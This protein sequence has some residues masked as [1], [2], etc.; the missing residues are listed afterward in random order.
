LENPK[1]D[2]TSFYDANDSNAVVTDTIKLE[3]TNDSNLLR[4][5]D[6]FCICS[7]D[8]GNEGGELSAYGTD[9]INKSPSWLKLHVVSIQDD[10]KLVYLDDDLTWYNNKN[11]TYYI[12]LGTVSK[13]KD[14]KLSIDE[15]RDVVESNYTVFSSKIP[16][17]LGIVA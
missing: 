14:G 7:S 16:G 4:A 5:G 8:V 15:Y 2:C 13:D 12:K 11:G 6:K 10:G 17:K 9:N 3:L 1:L